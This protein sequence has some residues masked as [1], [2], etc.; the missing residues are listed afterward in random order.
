MTLKATLRGLGRSP[1]SAARAAQHL[2]ICRAS[3]SS[4]QAARDRTRTHFFFIQPFHLFKY[5]LYLNK[6]FFYEKPAF[7]YLFKYILY[8]NE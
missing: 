1:R 2:T 4:R 8:L 7:M 3:G 5:I 6:C